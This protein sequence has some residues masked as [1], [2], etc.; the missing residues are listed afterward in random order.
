MFCPVDQMKIFQAAYVVGRYAMAEPEGHASQCDF[1]ML[2]KV[3]LHVISSVSWVSHTLLNDKRWP[4]DWCPRI[5]RAVSGLVRRLVPSGK[6]VAVLI[7]CNKQTPAGTVVHAG[8]LGV[9]V[10]RLWR[11][12]RPDIHRGG[13]WRRRAGVVEQEDRL[14]LQP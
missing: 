13:L 3:R 1:F 9:L 10:H 4:L 6:A 8:A 11:L 7:C 14:N 12:V 5:G 2:A